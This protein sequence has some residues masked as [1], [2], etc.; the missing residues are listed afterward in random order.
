MEAV[1]TKPREELRLFGPPFAGA[2]DIFNNLRLNPIPRKYPTENV[3]IHIHLSYS[4]YRVE[5]RQR[6][7][8]VELIIERTG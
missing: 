3:D 2:I 6:L 5:S 4:G 8:T 7:K 1:G